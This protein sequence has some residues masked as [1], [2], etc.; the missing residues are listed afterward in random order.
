MIELKSFA[1][2]N[3]GLEILGKRPDGYHNLKTVFQAIDL[4]DTLQVTENSTG[5]I[6]LTGDDTSIQW[7]E[8]NTIRRTL[9][10]VYKKYIIRQGFNITVKKQI[11]PGSGLGGGSSNAAVMLLFLNDHFKLNLTLEELIDIGMKIGADVPFF[12][13]GGTALAEGIGEKLTPL[14]DIEEKQ[15]DIVIPTV[16]VSTRLI[17]SQFNLTTKPI[18]ST[19]DTFVKSKNYTVLENHLETVTFKLVPQVE[20]IKANM[21]QMAYDLVLMSGSGSAVYGVHGMDG[22]YGS[23]GKQ[24]PGAALHPLKTRFPNSRVIVSRTIGRKKYF[25]RIGASPSGKASVF[26]ADTTEVRILPPQH[27]L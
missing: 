19:I 7:N 14:E 13:V 11:P 1:K 25:N 9:D 16:N 27:Y 3:L 15:V 20:A 21:K 5:E 17:F 2:I 12:L 6:H 18:N 4:F 8:Q 24:E 10:A 22:L 23:T 26:G